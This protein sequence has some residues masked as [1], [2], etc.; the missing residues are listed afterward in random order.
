MEYK[1]FIPLNVS[2]KFAI[3]GVPLRVDT[4]KT[5]SFGCKYCFANY[6]K[7]MEFEKELQIGNINWLKKKLDKVYN[8]NIYNP[9]TFLDMLI[10]YLV[11]LQMFQNSLVQN[12]PLGLLNNLSLIGHKTQEESRHAKEL[13]LHIFRRIRL[14]RHE[15]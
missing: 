11:H 12:V 10:N 9:E 4:Y 7:I 3:C 1:K 8:K 6:R 5:C 2:S 14:V 13:K 15:E